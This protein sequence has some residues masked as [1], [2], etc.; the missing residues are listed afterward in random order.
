[1][2]NPQK[3]NGH[4]QIANE[5]MEALGRIRI[6]GEARQVLDVIIRKT[7]GWNKKND[8]ISLSQFCLA[9]S[10]KKDKIIRARN[11]LQKM[12]LICVSQKGND[13]CQTYLFNKDFES[14]KPFPK[15]ET[16]PK[17]EMI[18][19]QKGNASYPKKEPTKDTTTKDTTTKDKDIRAS[20]DERFWPVWKK[21]V[22]KVGAFK[23]WKALKPSEE[24]IKVIVGDVIR[25]MELE[26]WVKEE[27]QFCPNPQAYLN[28]RRWEDEVPA[29]PPR[30]P[31]GFL[32]YAKPDPEEE[33]EP[34]YNPEFRAP[35]KGGGKP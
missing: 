13:L 17:K 23:A 24:L 29:P 26:D 14:W 10:M 15:K 18:V 7:W 32:K 1:M 11:K 21:R 33:D 5:V 30:E 31:L 16:F 27:R 3:E 34:G 9:T 28:G 4:T 2:A 35:R 19:S 6:P 22:N 8:Q 25:R 20:F 12:N